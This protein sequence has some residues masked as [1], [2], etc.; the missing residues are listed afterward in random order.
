MAVKSD[1]TDMVIKSDIANMATK[2]DLT[3]MVVKSDITDMATKSDLTDMVVK[4]DIA[5][6]IE[7]T[8]SFVYTPEVKDETTGEVIVPEVSMTIAQL[9][10]KIKTLETRII[11][12]E[13]KHT[14]DSNEEEIPTE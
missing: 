8:T 12:L 7:T 10:E 2:S 3:D 14:E 11:E 6:M 9:M 13:E 5:N 4:S 1:L